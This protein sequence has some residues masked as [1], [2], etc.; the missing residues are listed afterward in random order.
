MSF[1]VDAA[2]QVIETSAV[3]TLDLKEIVPYEENL[4]E[5]LSAELPEEYEPDVQ[6]SDIEL[7][8]NLPQHIF[9]NDLATTQIKNESS[10]AGQDVMQPQN[11]DSNE[12]ES[13]PL[14][15]ASS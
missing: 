3:S 10:A 4:E 5:V 1:T 15:E 8:G 14:L 11:Q 6:V 2:P 12:V 9:I 7:E 13:Q